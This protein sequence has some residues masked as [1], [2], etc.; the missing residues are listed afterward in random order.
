[1]YAVSI[2]RSEFELKIIGSY[3]YENEHTTRT[4]V[5]YLIEFFTA[6]S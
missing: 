5:L 4:N 2:I 3:G 1:M 6:K